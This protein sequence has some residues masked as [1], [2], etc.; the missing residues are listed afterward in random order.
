MESLSSLKRR[1]LRGRAHALDPVVIIGSGGLTPAVLAEIERNL[2]AHELIKIRVP[3][4]AREDRE[5]MLESVCRETGAAPVQHIGKIL[6]VFR[7]RPAQA[8]ESAHAA[9]RPAG[10][11]P[12]PARRPRQ[13]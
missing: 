8:E 6:L 10:K 9:K 11:R 1:I 3:D 13:R 12:A 4:A 5:S 7:E 2:A